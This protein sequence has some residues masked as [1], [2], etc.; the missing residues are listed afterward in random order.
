MR[1][2][3]RRRAQTQLQTVCTGGRSRKLLTEEYA[4]REISMITLA[5]RG[6]QTTQPF[7]H[8]TKRTVSAERCPTGPKGRLVHMRVG[9]KTGGNKFFFF[10]M[11]Q[12]K[13][14]NKCPDTGKNDC[15]VRSWS[16]GSFSPWKRRRSIAAFIQLAVKHTAR[17]TAIRLLHYRS[18]LSGIIITD[19][20]HPSPVRTYLMPL[21]LQTQE[22]WTMRICMEHIWKQTGSLDQERI[23][24]WKSTVSSFPEMTG[25]KDHS[26]CKWGSILLKIKSIIF[27]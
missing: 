12:Q 4:E 26:F 1:S 8:Y 25:S 17:E 5:E 19:V 18:H 2:W 13:S 7:T 15:S 9:L 16:S 23:S 10:L 11:F 3:R 6:G 22:P 24:H 20:L 21:R 14:D 27:F